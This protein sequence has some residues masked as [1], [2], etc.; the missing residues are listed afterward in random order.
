[1]RNSINYV[2]A[3]KIMLLGFIIS[4]M[5][6]LIEILLISLM[7]HAFPPVVPVFN[8]M[9]WGVER[10]GSKDQLFTPLIIGIFILIGNFFFSSIIYQ[11]IPLVARILCVT[12]VLVSLFSLLFFV[13]LMQIIL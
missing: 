9:P 8:Q 6:L 10:L 1:M 12:T 2:F 3:D 11:K 4:V 5:L 13:R 7:F